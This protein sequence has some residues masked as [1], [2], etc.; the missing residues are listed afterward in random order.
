MKCNR[1]SRK[2]NIAFK[3]SSKWVPTSLYRE[4]V[5]QS[6][7]AIVGWRYHKRLSRRFPSFKLC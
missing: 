5:A 7:E 6:K 1:K 2:L 4:I 3:F